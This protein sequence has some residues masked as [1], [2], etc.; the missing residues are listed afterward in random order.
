M[1]ASHHSHL[2]HWDAHTPRRR[3]RH[4]IWAAPGRRLVQG[5]GLAQARLLVQALALGLALGLALT[6]CASG[7]GE[8]AGPAQ[9]AG[10]AAPA[11]E[12]TVF[13]AASLTG[14]FTRLGK[15]FE[16]ANQGVHVRFNFAG[17]SALAQQVNQGAPADVFASASPA[18]LRQVSDA[19]GVS[20]TASVFARNR[21][22]IAVPPGNPGGVT[23]LADFA[24][25]ELKIALCAEQVP[26][27]AAAAAALRAAGV[28]AAPDTLEQDV[29][30][31][32]T[33]VLLGEVDAALVYRTDVLAAGAG[34][35]GIEFPQAGAAVNEYPIAVLAGT[36]N[37]AAAR[38]FVD[39]VLSAA[40]R[41]AL[42]EAGF[43][44]PP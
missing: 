32:L 43:D 39:F 17:S 31:T 15:E 26:C 40:G 29:K 9:P 30:A 27:G 34:V 13:A 41:A 3:Q 33:K 12:L 42:A 24:R 21:L 25:P 18:N 28:T 19:G 1:W 37:P 36:G 10:T 7:G 14:V 4:R 23:G 11:G 35:R 22:E 6:G 20:G 44:A 8:P 16:A 5:L 2:E 38:A